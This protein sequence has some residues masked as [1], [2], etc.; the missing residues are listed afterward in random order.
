MPVGLNAPALI[1]AGDHDPGDPRLV[2]GAEGMDDLRRIAA[3]AL[4]ASRAARAAARI[5]CDA[6]RATLP[7][8]QQDAARTDRMPVIATGRPDHPLASAVAALATSCDAGALAVDLALS[9]C[10]AEDVASLTEV[11][12]ET[13]LSAHLGVAALRVVES[14]AERIRLAHRTAGTA[15]LTCSVL[16]TRAAGHEVSGTRMWVNRGS[17]Q[18]PS[19]VRTLVRGLGDRVAHRE[20]IDAQGDERVAAAAAHDG[21]EHLM[22]AYERFRPADG[23]DGALRRY[24]RLTTLACAYAGWA[25]LALEGSA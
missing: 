13:I 25:T 21:A 16:T 14:S 19:S 7:P 15:H 20:Q 10:D 24:V 12:D 11:V 2:R 6:Y 8:G 9:T 17:S 22:R 18:L 3:A 1:A 23:A 5:A 4:E